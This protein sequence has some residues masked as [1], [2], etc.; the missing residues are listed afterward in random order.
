MNLETKDKSKY[1]L[2]LIEEAFIFK[3]INCWGRVEVWGKIKILQIPSEE[4]TDFDG[5]CVLSALSKLHVFLTSSYDPAAELSFEMT[6]EK[7]YYRGSIPV[8]GKGD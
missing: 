7:G 1:C 4:R 3:V 2:S 6:G 8:S 5:C